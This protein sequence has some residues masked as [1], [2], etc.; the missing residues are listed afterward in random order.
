MSYGKKC[1]KQKKKENEG[2]KRMMGGMILGKVVREELS[3]KITLQ[4]RPKDR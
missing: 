1:F 2:S 4:Q 3:K